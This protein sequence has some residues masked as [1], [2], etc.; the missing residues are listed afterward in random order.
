[1]YYT[2]YAVMEI[3]KSRNPDFVKKDGNSIMNEAISFDIEVTSMRYGEEKIAFMYVWMLDIFDKTII[4]RT[5]PEFVQ[6]MNTIS[7]Y[8]DLKNIKRRMIVYVHNLQYE[9]SFIRKWF[10]WVKVFSLS[11]RKPLFAVTTTGI[12]FRCSYRLSGYKLEK[13][14]EM[15]GIEKLGDFDYSKIRHSKTPLTPREYE[16]C[17]HDVKIVTAYI[18]QKIAEEHHDISQIPLTKTGYVRRYVRSRTIH[19]NNRCFY[20]NAIKDLTLEV[21][22]YLLAKKCFAGGFTHASHT[23]A[24]KIHKAVTSF[25]FGSSYPTVLIAEKYPMTKGRLIENMTRAE[26][27]DYMEREECCIFTIELVNV[28]Q[29]FLYEH[30]ISRSRCDIAEGYVVDNGRIVSAD[31]LV[32]NITSVDYNIIKKVY[33]FKVNRIGKFYLYEKYYLPTTFVQCILHFFELKTKLKGVAGSEVEYMWAKENLNALFGMAVTDIVREIINYDNDYGWDKPEKTRK[34]KSIKEYDD[35]EGWVVP[36][37]MTDEEYREFVSNQLDKENNK[38]SRF[39]Y[40]LWGVFCTAYARKNLWSGILECRND[41]IYSDTDSVKILN[42]KKH[43]AYFDRYN[44]EITEKLNKALDYHHISRDAI[45]PKNIK[46]ETK[47][48]GVWEFDGFY[49]E[50]KAIRAKS[51]MYLSSEDKDYHYTIA[52]L[53]KIDPKEK[54]KLREKGIIKKDAI[55]YLKE[56]GNPIKQFAYDM[57]I[58]AEYTQKLTH[59]YIDEPI[60]LLVTD[61]KGIDYFVHEL[62]STHLEPAEYHLSE[63]KIMEDLLKGATPNVYD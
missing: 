50:F 6:T 36:D 38:K 60:S 40:F 2:P 18:K 12:E 22:E 24:S 58:P 49:L 45:S 46:G 43:K 54:K 61:Y 5:W 1:M 7:D 11:R 52:G 62:S 35:E 29:T 23:K 42:A 59:T 30:Y 26:F 4:G 55:D 27:D 48:L 28:Q 32:L 13:V 41:Y 8:F 19:G 25:D 20:K 39:L 15:M 57:R 9:F 44:R 31:R 34:P 51:Y 53:P 63:A 47:H 14:G 21:D 3:L 37:E 16:Y 56:H 10:K 17:I 33:K